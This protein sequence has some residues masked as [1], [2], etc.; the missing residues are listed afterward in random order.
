MPSIALIVPSP[1]TIVCLPANRFLNKPASNV[2][3]NIPR[4]PPFCLFAAFLIV[5]LTAFINKLVSSSD[6]TFSYY[7]SFI[8][9][10]LLM[11]FAFLSPKDTYLIQTLC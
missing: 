1:D 11:L 2:P 3:N 9:Q 7:H 6:L 5:S 4:N 10:N 8:H